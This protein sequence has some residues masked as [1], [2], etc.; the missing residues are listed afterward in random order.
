MKKNLV[1]I[2][3]LLMSFCSTAQTNSKSEILMIET[4]KGQIIYDGISNDV[5]YSSW[6]GNNLKLEFAAKE[7]CAITE[8]L[9]FISITADTN[10][11]YVIVNVSIN[12]TVSKDLLFYVQKLPTPQL[13]FNID[14]EIEKQTLP[15]EIGRAEIRNLKY[16]EA[17]VEIGRLSWRTFKILSYEIFILRK[18]NIVERLSN[19]RAEMSDSNYQKLLSL[20]EGDMFSFLNIVCTDNRDTLKFNERNIVVE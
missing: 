17:L 6:F 20:N 13:F 4:S 16:L 8:H 18:N 3:L 10:S 11:K 7:N 2:V 14:S 15:S 9:G 19:E 5:F 1:L 12:D